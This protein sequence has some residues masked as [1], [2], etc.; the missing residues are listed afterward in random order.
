MMQLLAPIRAFLACETPD[1][2]IEKA[3][4]PEMLQDILI[5]HCNCELKAAQTALFLIRKYAVTPESAEALL[6]WS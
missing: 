3:R 1:A 2:W 5:D 6:S 4:R